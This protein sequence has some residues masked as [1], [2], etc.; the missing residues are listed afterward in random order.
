[1]TCESLATR[2]LKRDILDMIWSPQRWFC[3]Q[4]G[5]IRPRYLRRS[6]QGMRCN[7][8][9][10]QGS[11]NIREGVPDDFLHASLITW[12]SDKGLTVDHILSHSWVLCGWRIIYT[13]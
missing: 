5:I 1:M 7:E 8:I 12:V 4:D 11:E 6:T 9:F 10:G 13:W 2:Y 3:D